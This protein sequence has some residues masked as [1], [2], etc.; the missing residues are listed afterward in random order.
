[1]QFGNVILASGSRPVKKLSSEVSA[2]GI[3]F[4]TVGDCIMPGRI[5]DAIHGG[6]LAALKI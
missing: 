2:L 1:M 5:N 6:F 4:T 3:P